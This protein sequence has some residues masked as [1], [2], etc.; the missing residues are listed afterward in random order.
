MILTHP[1]TPLCVDCLPLTQTL[2]SA[3]HAAGF[4]LA[5]ATSKAPSATVG[6]VLNGLD[7]SQLTDAEVSTLVTSGG[8]EA[9]L[10]SLS[11]DGSASES[12]IA[13][14]VCTPVP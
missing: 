4:D 14:K 11:G 10:C 1:P 2:A 8:V 12:D 6:I 9:I 5:G 3:Q 13:L 7:A